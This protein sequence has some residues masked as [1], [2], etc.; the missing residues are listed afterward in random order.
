MDERPRRRRR[1]EGFGFGVAAVTLG[2][3]GFIIAFVPCAGIVAIPLG[4]LAFIVGIIGTVAPASG[5]DR[6]MAIAGLILGILCVV[7]ALAWLVILADASTT[8]QHRVELGRP[9]GSCAGA[10][11]VRSVLSSR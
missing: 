7:V 4:G 1:Q 2:I 5:S 10:C 3:I 11:C 8:R 6:G 9:E